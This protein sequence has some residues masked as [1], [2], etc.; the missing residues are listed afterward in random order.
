MT[1]SALNTRLLTLCGA[2]LMIIAIAG[3][4]S[5]SSNS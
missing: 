5:G 1:I 3:C 2:V 4:D